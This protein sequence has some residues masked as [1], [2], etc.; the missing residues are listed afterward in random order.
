M[1]ISALFRTWENFHVQVSQQQILEREKIYRQEKNTLFHFF[2]RN[3]CVLEIHTSKYVHNALFYPFTNMGKFP[4]SILAE[5]KRR[6]ICSLHMNS[7]FIFSELFRMLIQSPLAC[8]SFLLKKI[9]R[10]HF[11]ACR[12]YP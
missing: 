9:I 2:K 8:I 3:A 11:L 10:E 6:G 5:M 4:C 12:C 7:S 1:S